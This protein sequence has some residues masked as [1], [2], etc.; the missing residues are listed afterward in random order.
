MYH[1]NNGIYCFDHKATKQAHGFCFSMVNQAMQWGRDVVVSNTFIT[2]VSVSQ[3]ANLAEKYGYIFNVIRMGNR[4]ETVHA[5]PT[6][7]TVSMAK[8]FEEYIGETII[9]N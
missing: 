3:Y 7:V 1:M 8:S 5:V 6:D 2:V 4:Y 9:N